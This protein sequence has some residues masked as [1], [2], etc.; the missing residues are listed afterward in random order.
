VRARCDD[1]IPALRWL[2]PRRPITVCGQ[3][4]YPASANTFRGLATAGSRP[5]KPAASICH[6]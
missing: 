3:P 2:R 1:E 6:G 5:S 4:H